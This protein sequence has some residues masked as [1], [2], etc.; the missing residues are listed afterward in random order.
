MLSVLSSDWS[1]LQLSA[2]DWSRLK[3]CMWVAREKYPRFPRHGRFSCIKK[4]ICQCWNSL[5]STY[6]LYDL[7]LTPSCALCKFNDVAFSSPMLQYSPSVDFQ[8]PGQPPPSPRF[9]LQLKH[10][11]YSR[12]VALGRSL[13]EQGRTVLF[14]NHFMDPF[15]SKVSA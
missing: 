9:S 6:A 1:I 14:V 10:H 5:L 3:I 7:S 4:N 2:S 8:I 13:E 11:K 12:L 15:I